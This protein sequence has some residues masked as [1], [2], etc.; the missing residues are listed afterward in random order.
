MEVAAPP[1]TMMVMIAY[2]G[3]PADSWLSEFSRDAIT[4]LH[5]GFVEHGRRAEL[6]EH[7]GVLQLWVEAPIPTAML[8]VPRFGI[9]IAGR[10]DDPT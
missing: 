1:G 4:Q 7:E 5:A 9:S 6:R 2:E 3:G 10:G 8:G